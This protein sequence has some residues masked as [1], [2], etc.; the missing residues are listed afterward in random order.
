MCGGFGDF[1]SDIFKAGLAQPEGLISGDP[2]KTAQA[3]FAPSTLVS[4]QPGPVGHL[5]MLGDEAVAGTVGG[6]FG[7]VP[8]AFGAA[9]G[10]GAFDTYL[11]GGSTSDI[12]R[13]GLTAGG[14]AA[15]GRVAGG[16]GSGLFAPAASSATSGGLDIAGGGGDL[17]TTGLTGGAD[18]SVFDISGGVGTATPVGGLTGVAPTSIGAGAGG[19]SLAG[20]LGSANGGQGQFLTGGSSGVAAPAVGGGTQIATGAGGVG[21]VDPTKA[22]FSS[23]LNSPSVGGAGS[24]LKSAVTN[25]PLDILNGALL[26]KSALTQNN[27]PGMKQLEA[28]A[29]IVSANSQAMQNALN[30]QLP[31]LAA[32]ALKAASNSAKASV[33]SY[34]AANGLGNSTI[35][36][37]MEQAIDANMAQQ[38]FAI[39]DKL[40]AQGVDLASISSNM[41]ASIL[42]ANTT[43]NNALM[44]SIASFSA[45]LVPAK[46][47]KAA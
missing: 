45:G 29:A 13:A 22:A 15:A 38:T 12:E 21:A 46:L 47:G 3:I 27:I 26:A 28:N 1:I 30:G 39:A 41:W 4:E 18:Q 31:P 34:L 36:S 25:H 35:A 23:F 2:M 37:S 32:N 9:G 42:Q 8:G 19:D 43:Q 24:L 7:G 14:A 6:I 10:A 20:L 17:T 33:R 40:V 16:L 44:Q 11:R 5:S